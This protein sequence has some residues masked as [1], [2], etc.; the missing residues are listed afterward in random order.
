MGLK[1]MYGKGVFAVLEV[2]LSHIAAVK[3][4]DIH[5]SPPPP[6]P[7]AELSL[8]CVSVTAASDHPLRHPSCFGRATVP[9]MCCLA[10]LPSPLT[11]QS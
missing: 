11:A 4:N 2:W 7:P 1:C 3:L 8:W 6:P 5:H 10:S 9:R